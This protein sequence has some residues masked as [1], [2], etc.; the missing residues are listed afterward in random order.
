LYC[1]E[2]RKRIE[3]WKLD[4]RKRRIGWMD[5]R[6]DETKESDLLMYT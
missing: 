6:M 4:G 1:E 3:F 2:W 5:G